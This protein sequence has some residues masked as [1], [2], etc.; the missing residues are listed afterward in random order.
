M[1]TLTHSRTGARTDSRPGVPALD[2]ARVAGLFYLGVAITGALGFLVIRPALFQIGDPAATTAALLDNV[3]LARAG[4]GVDLAL[5]VLQA[6]AALWFYKLFRGVDAFAAGMIAV[7]GMVNAV[8]ILASTAMTATALELALAPAGGRVGDPHLMY[9]I[10]ENLWGVGN[11]FFGLWLIPM[12]WCAVR[13]LKMP[14]VL[15]WVLIVGGV[16]YVLSGFTGYLLPSATAL[17]G[18]LPMV[19]T[20]GEVWMVGYLLIKGDRV[21][22][23]RGGSPSTP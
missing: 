22:G 9:L 10:S 13:S 18:A 20:I 21:K 17:T 5:V 23:D 12:G 8:A 3:G 4:L 16:G 1:T 2:T 14:S 7:F 6:L 15:G 11:L 19:A